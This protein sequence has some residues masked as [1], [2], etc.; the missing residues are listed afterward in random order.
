MVFP[1]FKNKFL[2]EALFSPEEFGMYKKWSKDKFPKKMIFCYQRSLLSYF[3]RKYKG[4][5]EKIKISKSQEILKLG[6]IGFMK[7][8]G[9]GAPHAATLMEELIAHG[10]REIINLGTAGGLS[11]PGVFLCNK[12]VRDEGTSH[13]YLPDSI[14]SYP[15]ENLTK[16]LAK[17]LEEL[18][19]NYKINPTW[20]IDAPYRETK[21]EIFHYKKMGIKTVE[22]EAAALFAVAKIRKVKIASL[23]AVSD[24]LGE[25]WDPLFHKMDLKRILN[26]LVDASINCFKQK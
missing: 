18:G 8:N 13:H 15:D 19:I 12:A 11:E 25:K 2:E 23:F 5:Y 24:V 6:E 20:T 7:M 4:K 9:I 17:S 22:M 21:R 10:T 1:K 26:R 14:Y 3:K 16:R